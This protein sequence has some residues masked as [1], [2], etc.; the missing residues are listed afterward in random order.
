MWLQLSS[1][2]LASG[3]RT[4]TPS[5]TLTMMTLQ[6]AVV[7]VAARG[8]QLGAGVHAAHRCA[9]SGQLLLL[10]PQY[11]LGDP[12][13]PGRA[14]ALG[15]PVCS[16]PRGQR[17]PVPRGHLV[18]LGLWTVASRIHIQAQWHLQGGGRR[19]LPQ[20]LPGSLR[21]KQPGSS[22][23]TTG[24]QGCGSRASSAVEG[25]GLV[26]QSVDHGPHQTGVFGGV[27]LGLPRQ[28]D[29]G[30]NPLSSELVAIASS[31]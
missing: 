31:L 1:P 21:S 9:A 3:S 18:V 8:V 22:R 26:G 30:N 23:R 28:E 17:W 25:T 2:S 4:D 27:E 20:Q 13:H 10:L 19:C 5:P 7:H 16:H 29:K 11:R 24:C 6:M 14:A 15:C 12:R